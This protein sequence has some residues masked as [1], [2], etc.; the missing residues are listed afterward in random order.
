MSVLRRCR[1]G[2]APV[3]PLPWAISPTYPRPLV[4]RDVTKS[5][6]LQIMQVSCPPKLCRR[7]FGGGLQHEIVFDGVELGRHLLAVWRRSG[8]MLDEVDDQRRLHAIDH[9]SFEI[10]AAALEQ[11][12]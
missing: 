4:T 12:G 6:D 1:T 3:R 7:R 8:R 2:T 10:R 9:V 5:H 11:V